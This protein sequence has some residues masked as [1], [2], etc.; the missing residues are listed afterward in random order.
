MKA[1]KKIRKCFLCK[2][3][4][5]DPSNL[6]HV[7]TCYPIHICCCR[8]T[9]HRLS[10]PPNN[11]QVQ[12]HYVT[13]EKCIHTPDNMIIHCLRNNYIASLI[14][15]N[16]KNLLRRFPCRFILNI[17]IHIFITAK[18]GEILK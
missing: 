15:H 7:S 5:H 8:R 2:P 10:P 14:H 13:D 9:T 16:M 3:V 1:W 12:G 4:I 17:E 11:R 18:V 6:S